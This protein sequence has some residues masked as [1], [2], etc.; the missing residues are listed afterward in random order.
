MKVKEINSIKSRIVNNI[1]H[2]ITWFLQ[3]LK[4]AAVIKISHLLS[5]PDDA[6]SSSASK[7]GLLCL[8]NKKERGVNEGENSTFQTGNYDPRQS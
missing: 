8:E 4:H 2:F 6:L 7:Y 3:F 5:G 1:T